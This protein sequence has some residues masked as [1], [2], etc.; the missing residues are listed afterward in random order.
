MFKSLEIGDRAKLERYYFVNRCR[1]CDN[2]FANIFCWR[3]MFSTQWAEIE[4]FLVVRFVFRSDGRLYYMMPLGENPD[5]DFTSIL[6]RLA[7]DA[8]REGDVLRLTGLTARGE[9]LLR[10]CGAE[11]YAVDTDRDDQDY[12]YRAED[13][14]YLKGE[15]YAAKRNHINKFVSKYDYEFRA[16]TAEH[17]EECMRLVKEW[18]RRRGGCSEEMDAEFAAMRIAFENFEQLGLM[19]GT[20]WVDGKIVAF[21]YGSAVSEEVFC[22]HVEKADTGYD[23]AFAMINQQMALHLPDKFL[24]INR[25]EDMGIAGLRKAKMSYHPVELC[26]NG[27]A[28]RL[29]KDLIE[30]KELWKECFGDEDEFIDRFL[31]RFY[32]PQTTFLHREEER[33]VAMLHVVAFTSAFGRTGYVYAVATDK[34]YRRRGLAAELLREAE[35]WCRANGFDALMLIPQNDSLVRYYAGLDFEDVALRVKFEGGFDFGTGVPEKDLAM[36][37]ALTERADFVL[38][39]YTHDDVAMLVQEPAVELIG[40]SVQEGISAP[41]NGCGNP[42]DVFVVDTGQVQNGFLKKGT[43]DDDVLILTPIY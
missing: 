41:R 16:L 25:E 26:E 43:K 17:Y 33:V 11:R 27:C 30:V 4:G 14:R 8:A 15:K 10:R 40:E 28:L 42:S 6:P 20:L 31:V 32:S 35:E 29:D 21:T 1:S 19:G 12:I 34:E 36:V 2:T 5:A 22:T 24:Y 13:L 3:D 7:E 23:G 39:G 37:M 9:E 18:C 38:G